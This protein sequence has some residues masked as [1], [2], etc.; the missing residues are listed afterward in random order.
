MAAWEHTM[1][2]VAEKDPVSEVIV[3]MAAFTATVD[4]LQVN[5]PE[6]PFWHPSAAATVPRSV[7]GDTDGPPRIFRYY[8]HGPFPRT[9]SYLDDDGTTRT[10]PPDD[11]RLVFVGRSGDRTAR[12]GGIK[13]GGTVCVALTV[14][15]PPG[16]G[17]GETAG[18]PL[19]RTAGTAAMAAADAA[20]LAFF[21]EAQGQGFMGSPPLGAELEGSLAIVFMGAD[22]TVSEYSRERGFFDPPGGF[23]FEERLVDMERHDLGDTIEYRRFWRS[24]HGL[25]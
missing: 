22:L 24:L 14:L 16:V 20:L 23:A 10:I 21:R 19:A 2:R 8:H 4:W 5:F 17:E 6:D 9:I 25:Q 18:Q 15:T 7:D 13:Q 1:Q 12:V 3:R 11:T